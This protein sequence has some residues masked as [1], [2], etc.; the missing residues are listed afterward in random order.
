MFERIYGSRSSL[1]RKLVW[2]GHIM[3]IA[4]PCLSAS[5]CGQNRCCLRKVFSAR[6]LLLMWGGQ[7]VFG[8]RLLSKRP[9]AG[10]GVGG[11]GL[12]RVQ[13]DAYGRY[14][15]QGFCC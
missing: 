3:R 7:E 14:F 12:A 15:L 13:A 9:F 6:I 4:A 2:Q 8:V 11:D 10:G 1:P 5:P